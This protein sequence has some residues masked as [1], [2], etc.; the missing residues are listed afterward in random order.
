MARGRQGGGGVYPLGQTA[1]ALAA[2]LAEEEVVSDM[3]DIYV[4][5]AVEKARAIRAQSE[6][7]LREREGHVQDFRTKE[8]SIFGAL[9]KLLDEGHKGY[10][11][12][13]Q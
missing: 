2:D 4:T 10:R 3:A 6:S 9:Y 5:D 12:V 8:R 7:G 13:K 11:L 1:K